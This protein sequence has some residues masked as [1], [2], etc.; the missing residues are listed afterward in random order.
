MIV[1]NL[2][3]KNAKA[4]GFQLIWHNINF[5]ERTDTL[6]A[7]WIKGSGSFLSQGDVSVLCQRRW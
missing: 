6:F 7:I 2:E 5:K 4:G 3:K 1:N